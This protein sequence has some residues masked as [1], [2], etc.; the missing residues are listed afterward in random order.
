[1]YLLLLEFQQVDQWKDQ[2]L[3]PQ[4]TSHLKLYMQTRRLHLLLPS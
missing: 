1:M 4:A 3:V 2:G